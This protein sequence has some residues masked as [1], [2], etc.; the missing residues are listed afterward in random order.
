MNVGTIVELEN[1]LACEDD[2]EI[3]GGRRVHAWR[4]GLHMLRQ[5]WK[6]R[7]EL[8]QPGR[9]RVS[10]RRNRTSPGRQSEQPKANSTKWGKV[11]VCLRRRAVVGK[12][13]KSIGAPESMKL[14]ARD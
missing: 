1:D 8:L 11:R 5:S 2:F 14:G 10:L 7:F 3:N 12:V 4:V 9:N 6:L 13:R